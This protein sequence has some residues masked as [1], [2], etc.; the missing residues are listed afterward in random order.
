LRRR[1]VSCARIGFLE[2]PYF[3]FDV[4]CTAWNHQRSNCLRSRAAPITS[5]CRRL[6]VKTS[7][8]GLF[9]SLLCGFAVVAACGGLRAQ[10]RLPS[11]PGYANYEKMA[12]QLPGAVK[13]GA[14][15]AT[16][17]DGGKSLEYR[18]DGKRI[19]LDVATG[20]SE[21]M[22][23]PKDGGKDR[24]GSGPGRGR[25]AG[26]RNGGRGRERGGRGGAAAGRGRQ[27]T[28]SLSPDGQFKAFYRDR[29]VGA[30]C[31]G[32]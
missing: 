14:V 27:A 19:R 2:L 9:D 24:P 25:F 16:W 1:F 3:S 7:G 21:A 29:V 28:S 18:L 32:D 31:V 4:V 17:R 26:G 22:P 6:A 8:R 20:K 13:S 10:D 12:K 23:E 5:F 15:F 11:M 30:S